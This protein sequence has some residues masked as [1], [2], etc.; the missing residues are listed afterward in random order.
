MSSPLGYPK[1]SLSDNPLSQAPQLVTGKMCPR[2]GQLSAAV[3]NPEQ[4]LPEAVH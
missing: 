4:L 2:A 1:A 3:T